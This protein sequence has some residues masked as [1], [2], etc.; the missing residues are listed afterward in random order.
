MSGY[1]EVVNVGIDCYFLNFGKR[2]IS[3]ESVG[4]LEIFVYI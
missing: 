4:V 3:K 2:D 1:I